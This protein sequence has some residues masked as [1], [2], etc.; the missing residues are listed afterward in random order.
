MSRVRGIPRRRIVAAALGLALAVAVMHIFVLCGGAHGDRHTAAGSAVSAMSGHHAVMT[1]STDRTERVGA[2]TL[3][4][5]GH[6]HGC[7]FLR[8]E[9]IALVVILGAVT[10]IAPLARL[11]GVWIRRRPS[12]LGRAPPWAI[13]DH[14][15]LSV[16]VR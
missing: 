10:L 1:P 11:S 15:E 7:V 12:V 8:G 13:P 3:D 16:I 2:S 5:T 14:L 6:D 4:C 9:V